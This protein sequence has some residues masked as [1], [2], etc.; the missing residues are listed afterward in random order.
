MWIYKTGLMGHR[1]AW[2]CA[3]CSVSRVSLTFQERWR[4]MGGSNDE[5]IYYHGEAIYVFR[6]NSSVKIALNFVTSTRNLILSV[7]FGKQLQIRPDC[8][9]VLKYITRPFQSYRLTDNC[10]HLFMSIKWL[11]SYLLNYPFLLQKSHKN[12][13]NPIIIILVHGGYRRDSN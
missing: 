1:G 12:Q 3:S 7:F 8:A 9:N 10:Q 13:G 6:S 11:S 2:H 4:S 5:Q